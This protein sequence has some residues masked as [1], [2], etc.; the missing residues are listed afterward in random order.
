MIDYFDILYAHTMIGLIFGL[1]AIVLVL[2][3]V[4]MVSETLD[5]V[6]SP[7]TWGKRRAKNNCPGCPGCQK[8]AG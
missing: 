7:R 1:T 5:T 2:K 8:G 4:C 3:G 6:T